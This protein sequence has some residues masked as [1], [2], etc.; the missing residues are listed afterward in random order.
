MDAGLLNG[1]GQALSNGA[2]SFRQTQ[3]DR[4]KKKDDELNNQMRLLANNLQVD[5][6]SGLIK[7]DEYGE[8]DQSNKLEAAKLTGSGFDPESKYSG[9]SR[10]LIKG[11]FEGVNPGSGAAISDDMSQAEL[12]G[13]APMIGKDLTATAGAIRG[14]ATNERIKKSQD[15]A[16]QGIDLRK[17]KFGETQNNSAIKAGHAITNDPLVILGTK[18]T[19]GLD[20]A[21]GILTGPLP[22]T[23]K[24]FA[25]AQQDFINAVAG[26][27]SATE[28]KIDREMVKTWEGKLNEIAEQYGSVKDLRKEQPQIFNQAL[29]LM[30]QIRQEYVRASEERKQELALSMKQSSNPKVQKTI[31][32]LTKPQAAEA[33]ARSEGLLQ[34]DPDVLKYAAQ[35]KLPYAQALAI[36]Q[37]RKNA[38]T[39]TAPTK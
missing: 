39:P 34:D 18:T 22:V 3:L 23:G 1:I 33:Q 16:Q 28:G 12:Q 4:Q 24:S 25:L 5:P 38:L 2:S 32:D 20:R 6:T 31:A 14:R 7:R 36:I 17:D 15:L 9:H 26:G 21:I 35:Y 19:K 27:S 10:G 13:L 11:A 8:L 37:R 29:G 30:R